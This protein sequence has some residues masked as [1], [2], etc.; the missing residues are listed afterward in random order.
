MADDIV[1]TVRVRDLTRGD[2]ASVRQ[3][4]QGM[5][6]DI[7]QVG[8]S[9]D[10]TAQRTERLRQGLKGVSTGLKDLRRNGGG[11][12]HEMTFMRRT[13]SLL[14]RDLT[15]AARAGELTQEEFARLR[16]ELRGTRLDFDYLDRDIQRHS[17]VAQRAARETAAAQREASRRIQTLLRDESAAYR[18]AARRQLASQRET[19]RQINVL[20]RAE[21]AAYR[22]AARRRAAADRESAQSH[23]LLRRSFSKLTDAMQSFARRSPLVAAALLLIGPVAQAL[24][25]LLSVVLGGAFIALGAFALKGNAQ[26]K[27]SFLDMKSTVGSAVREAAEP[28]VPF[29]VEGMNQVAMA[30]IAMGPTLR[31]AFTATGPL[32]ED[33]FGAITDLAASALPGMTAALES[34][35]PAM[36]GFRT[37]MGFIGEGIGDLFQI[38]TGDGTAMQKVWTTIGSEMRNSLRVIGQ[39]MAD[40]NESG[41]ATLALIGIFRALN[42]II[43]ITTGIF[44]ALDLVTFGLFKNLADGITG[45]KNLAPGA[46]KG[47]ESGATS[48]STSLSTLKQQLADVNKE[49]GKQAEAKGLYESLK[50]GIFTSDRAAERL[51]EFD[52]D[53]YNKLL[54][55]RKV[56]EGA[57]AKATE[58][59]AAANS[60]YTKSLNDVVTAM[61]AVNQKARESLDARSSMEGA[62]DAAA[63]LTKDHA[64]ALKM[65]NG[66]LS[67]N[68]E[69]S[70]EAYTALSL[71][72][73]TTQ[74]AATKASKSGASWESVN[75]IYK[76]GRHQLIKMA[77]A[78]GLTK[79]EATK[80]ADR[81]LSMPHV[82]ALIKGNI[83]D[84]EDKLTKAR[85]KLKKAHGAKAIAKVQ[86]EINGFL[87]K[88]AV[89]RAALNLLEDKTVTVYFQQRR[90]KGFAGNPATG[91]RASGGIV[92]GPG[93]ETS[94]DIPMML[95]NNEF[96]VNA[97]Q[98]RKYRRLLED[99][100]SD[101]VPHFAKGGLTSG[102]KSARSEL[103]S[104]LS[105]STWGRAIGRKK[106]EVVSSLTSAG[107]LGE[108]ASALNKWQSMIKRAA[109]GGVE[110]RLLKALDKAGH[111]LIKYEK[112]LIG[113][114]AA[115][116]KAKSKLHE[117][118][119][120][121]ASMKE[122]I[123]S[124][125]MGSANIT[126]LAAGGTNVTTGSIIGNLQ[127]SKDQA[128]A[129]ADALKALKKRGLNAQSLS[130]IAAAGVEGGG[131]ETAQALMGASAS[132][133]KLINALEKA[134]AK[135]A[136]SAGKTTADA[137]YKAGIKAAEGVVKGLEKQKKSLEKTM[138]DI[139]KA[140]A[141]TLK[142]ELGIKSKSSGGP[143]GAAVGGPRGSRT[144]VGEM[145]PEIVD[146]PYGS[147]VSPAG[148]SRQ[149]MANG[150]GGG[151]EMTINLSIA[152]K[153]FEQ[154][155]VD[156]VRKAV[157][158]R[159]GNVQ[160]AL[161]I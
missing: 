57:V 122:S 14:E 16:D 40:M 146:L 77:D 68:S 75:A 28:L 78:M 9:S 80:L 101:R 108:L 158:V 48:S 23:G 34:M 114:N 139:A 18:E 143:I 31:A 12:N 125:I 73:N 111:S 147:M 3:R 85:A 161:G 121:A 4:L 116:E 25:A 47:L 21:T 56:L 74:S 22:E 38:M 105:I 123:K 98:T 86:A 142:R 82:T 32:I 91:G 153:N 76:R 133:I 124:G 141:K 62:I 137:M 1:L 126:G 99:I 69:A 45:V 110:K 90:N 109:S 63:K 93:S 36:Q 26:V 100:N 128:K 29:L 134:I 27:A 152:G 66:D 44:E 157:R 49:I 102:Q 112:K 127:T 42:G 129:L 154:I 8:Q 81:I 70:R 43:H 61:Q 119:D 5:N 60:G 106:N 117:L 131:L 7:R 50:G 10:L 118:K 115:L 55:E 94:D 155:T 11:A 72:A 59:S 87:H 71:L 53:A 88:I 46:F 135:S 6:R 51:S 145:G 13:L 97:G 17:A 37:A 64:N 136:G 84:L 24:A 52:P 120:A 140:F 113:V 67:Q 39:A 20:A 65:V 19:A 54:A 33:V 30:A 138:S 103:G 79:A 132:D 156:T 130:E 2:F 89:A 151:G 144:L 104:A 107:S 159:G 83:K 35:G 58:K 148:K 41:A 149:M 95:S 92:N 15:H 160:A 150:G 96:V